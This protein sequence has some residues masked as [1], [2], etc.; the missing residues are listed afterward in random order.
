M[1]SSSLLKPP[2]APLKSSVSIHDEALFQNL[3]M[4]PLPIKQID[5]ISSLRDSLSP[6]DLMAHLDTVAQQ[7]TQW[8][9]VAHMTVFT[10]E[11]KVKEQDP[12][13][14]TESRP[15]EDAVG[16]MQPLI[17][18]FIETAT[19]IVDDYDDADDDMDNVDPTARMIFQQRKM[20][21]KMA[22]AKIQSEWSGL[23]HFVSSVVKAIQS[24]AEE[25]SLTIA[26]EQILIQLNDISTMIFQYHEKK[27]L[28]LASS[29]TSSTSSS[30]TT[31]SSLF[32]SLSAETRQKDESI[33]AAID[34]RVEPVF[35]EVERVYVRMTSPDHSPTDRSG[36]LVRKHALVQSRWENLRAEI[37]DLKDELKEDRWLTVFRQVAD[38]VDV[39]IDGL[40]KTTA[41]C[42]AM[43]QQIRQWHSAGSNSNCLNGTLSDAMPRG[44]LKNG[45]SSQPSTTSISSSSSSGSAGYNGNGNN[46]IHHQQQPPPMDHYKFRSLEKNF[47]A[48]YKYYK[49]S[50]DRMLAMLG[51]GIA[52]RVGQD[53]TTSRRHQTMLQ[54]WQ[55]LKNEMDEM[56][57]RDLPETE[58]IL[59]GDRPISP[60]YS[61]FSDRSDRSM[62]SMRFRSP[63]PMSHREMTDYMLTTGRARSPLSRSTLSRTGSPL[64][65]YDD[66]RRGR[67]TTP[68][69]GM[70]GSSTTANGHRDVLRGV[71]TP[72]GRLQRTVSPLSFSSV[73]RP[74]TSDSSSVSSSSISQA[75]S[76][77][78]RQTNTSSTTTSDRRKSR[79]PDAG[80]DWG[81]WIKP[82]KS[83]LLRQQRTEEA[84][85]QQQTSAGVSRAKTPTHYNDTTLSSNSRANIPSSRPRSRQDSPSHLTVAYPERAISPI[86]RSGT[87]SMIPRPKTPS[88]PGRAAS[89]SMVPRPRSSMQ[90]AAPMGHSSPPPAHPQ[91]DVRRTLRKKQSMPALM[92]RAGSPMRSSALVHARTPSPNAFGTDDYHDNYDYRDSG[93][94]RHGY[95]M[96]DNDHEDDNEDYGYGWRKKVSVPAVKESVPAYK[97]DPKDPLDVEVGRI[98]N[99]SPIA[100]KCQKGPNGSGRYY[101]GSELSPSVGGGK[102][103]YTCKLMSYT[104]RRQ[105]SDTRSAAVRNKVLVRVGGGWQDLELFLLHYGILH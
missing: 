40:E 49:P 22:L 48:K 4:T 79:I 52:S 21:V 39:M 12:S 69:S 8:L 42:Y 61:R 93:G 75:L 45:P 78:Q 51:N 17:S 80:D 47:E 73:L 89:P 77:H 57:A 71:T 98:V 66:N 86:R 58:R 14:T 85:Q 92:H 31:S 100:I 24:I 74:S 16:Q 95:D 65:V 67:S 105:K 29:S 36:T 43:I 26:M 97:V 33:L 68:N 72:N 99:A 54:R 70:G 5:D 88:G 81:S 6:A 7:I 44:V 82:T 10:L 63:E 83:S 11:Q 64:N 87:P 76:E 34:E 90:L 35:R 102:K 53:M 38:Q 13:I 32:P 37:D 94:Y 19:E 50:I 103:L 55:Q 28:A 46:G 62:S 2:L 41:Q 104:G 96:E 23:Q 56:R 25:R 59:V 91:Q 18:V 1:D 101:F 3:Y 27:H 30:S 9:G 20:A 15:L 60:A 84:K